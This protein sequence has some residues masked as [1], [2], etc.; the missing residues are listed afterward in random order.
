MRT[1][2]IP[3]PREFNF[4]FCRDYL[5]RSPHEN[6]HRVVDHSVTKLLSL[7]GSDF[8]VR[9]SGGETRHIRVEY[10]YGQP[11]P[12]TQKMICDYVSAWFDLSTDLRPFYR[13]AKQDDLLS[14]L[15]KKFYGHR[16]VGHLDLFES[17]IWAV[18]GQQINLS[19][20]HKLKSRLVESFGRSLTVDGHVY[21]AFPTPS[22]ISKLDLGQ[23]AALQ[24]SRQKSAYVVGIAQAF[25]DGQLSQQGLSQ[26]SFEDAK[27]K[28]MTIKGIG[29]WTANYVLMKTLRFPNAFVLEDA[30]L[31][32]AIKHQLG[33]KTK[34][35][36]DRMK[37]IFRKYRGWEAYA[38]AYL[39]KSL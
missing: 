25:E 34:P 9:I 17:L 33:L 36:L 4:D 28:L 5:K 38:T 3:V 2:A 16:I 35:S 14:P 24:L 37:R 1:T 30:G 29:N 31:H 39:W 21:Y 15:I 22:V 10:L 32:N 7:N 18:L 6:L 23:L 20:A 13:L 27:D 12:T 19:F 8:I 26:L 11:S